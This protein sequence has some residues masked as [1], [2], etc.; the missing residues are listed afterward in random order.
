M[1]DNDDWENQLDSDYEEQK[2]QK[3]NSKFEGEDE[4]DTKQI[5]PQIKGN[6]K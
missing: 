6:I 2:T 3:V 4:V 1:S 5:L